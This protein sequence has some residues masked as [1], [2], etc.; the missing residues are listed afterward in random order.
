[1]I[2]YAHMHSSSRI[3]LF[4]PYLSLPVQHGNSV[5]P[6]VVPKAHVANL[7]PQLLGRL[8]NPGIEFVGFDEFIIVDTEVVLT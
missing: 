3:H 8:Q 4:T 7:A 5:A 1:M 2:E 6:P